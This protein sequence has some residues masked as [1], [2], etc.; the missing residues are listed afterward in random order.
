MPPS[1]P[2]PDRRL[3]RRERPVTGPVEDF[4][5]EE[6]DGPDDGPQEA[7]LARFG[8]VTI[9]CPECGTELFDDVALCWKCGRPVGAGAPGE[10]KGPPTWA[11]VVVLVIV[12]AFVLG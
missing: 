9:K 7:D 2:D 8:D 3:A 6:D 4:R 10:S 1:R 12:G 5:S 11:I